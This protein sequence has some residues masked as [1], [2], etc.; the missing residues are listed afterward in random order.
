M[1]T[2]IKGQVNYSEN[3]RKYEDTYF[4]NSTTSF[5]ID[6]IEE[7]KRIKPL[8]PKEHAPY[9]TECIPEGDY[10]DNSGVINVKDFD[11]IYYIIESDK[12]LI[13]INN[14]RELTDTNKMQFEHLKI[15]QFEIIEANLKTDDFVYCHGRVVPN[16]SN[17]YYKDYDMIKI[18]VVNIYDHV[19]PYNLLSFKA[20]SLEAANQLIYNIYKENNTDNYLIIESREDNLSFNNHNDKLTLNNIFISI[21][22]IVIMMLIVNTE[23]IDNYIK[24]DREKNF[25]LFLLGKPKLFMLRKY[26]VVNL[27][28]ILTLIFVATILYLT[29][30]IIISPLM[31]VIVV[32]IESISL[33]IYSRKIEFRKLR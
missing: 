23:L 9:L 14:G 20:E 2:L 31:I 18:E 27:L 33:L 6:Y 25:S 21:T 3:L 1:P 17:L 12:N 32:V 24:N 30:S 5:D 19:N 11:S 22:S 8:I 7:I 13:T 4:I 15:D 26:I 10:S 28:L 16:Y 29:S